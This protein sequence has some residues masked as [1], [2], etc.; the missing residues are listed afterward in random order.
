ML[1]ALF[2]VFHYAGGKKRYKCTRVQQWCGTTPFLNVSAAFKCAGN[3]FVCAT[4]MFIYSPTNCSLPRIYSTLC[5]YSWFLL[6][7]CFFTKPF[8]LRLTPEQTVC[9]YIIPQQNHPYINLFLIPYFH[10]ILR[11][12]NSLVS[13]TAKAS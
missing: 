4:Q 11:T 13:Y 7:K 2:M 9:F 3:Y 8:S 5:L 1:L 6:G 10:D 12:F